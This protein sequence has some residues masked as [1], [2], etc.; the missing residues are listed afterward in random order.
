MAHNH[1]KII[2]LLMIKNESKIIQRCLENIIDHVDAI[3]ILDTGSTDNTI[4]L[5]TDF[6]NEK[7]KPFKIEI[8]PFRN[9]G[10]NRTV[11]FRNAQKFCSEIGYDTSKTYCLA[12]DGDMVLKS[13]TEFKD[14]L[15]TQDGYSII[16]ENDTIKYYNT[17]FMRCN[18]N[19]N[20]IGATH[21]YWGGGNIEKIDYEIIYIRD[22]GDG[23]SKS[24]KFERD[25]RLLTEELVENPENARAMFY[26]AQSYK[27]IGK[28]REAIDFYK[29]RIKFNDFYEERWYS[30]YMIGMMYKNLKEFHKMEY[31]LNRAF[32]FHPVRSEPIY[33]L[34]K[35][36]RETSQH[37]KAYHYYLKG[38]HIQ[39]PIHNVLFVE[40]NIYNGSFEYENTILSYYVGKDFLKI[41]FNYLMRHED[42]KNNCILNLRFSMKPIQSVI[43]KLDIPQVFGDEFIPSSISVYEYPLV[44]VRFVNYR[45][46][47]Y[48]TRNGIVKTRNLKYNIKTR[49]YTEIKNNIPIFT[50]HIIGIEDMRLYKQ[51]GKIMYTASNYKEYDKD[52]III[53]NGEYEKEE[54]KIIESPL[55]SY[56]EKNWL[57]IP[58]TDSFIYSWSPLRIGKIKDT[59]FEFTH[60]INTIPIFKLFRGSAAP[61]KINDKLVC[62]VHF[63]DDF[64]NNTVKYNE[65]RYY[66]CFIELDLNSYNHT[67]VSYPFTFNPI[68]SLDANTRHIEYCLSMHFIDND[69]IQCF[70]SFDDSNPTTFD[71]CTSN[72]QW[73]N[74]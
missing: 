63:V 13:T 56:C 64:Y 37:Y 39:Y 14:T 40:K 70:V 24:D 58:D 38:S 6:L 16:Q 26:L 21:E 36:Y 53:V 44:N 2:G 71:I 7:S 42:N 8:E 33:Q 50:S 20:C 19:W 43:N 5:A 34:T 61:V 55:N 59:K 1:N 51:D 45:M 46:P 4:E 25:I 57:H 47:G 22:I 68:T 27:D 3:Y 66:H 11:S 29:K 73:T 23:G 54:F 15:L 32:D 74:I 49:E 67:R 18:C 12:L 72:I 31:W 17:R 30:H 35:Y 48:S 28:Y 52:R 60:E 41:T 69:T 62:L 10:Y 9:F 65:R